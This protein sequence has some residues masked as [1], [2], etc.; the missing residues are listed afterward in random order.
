MDG[1][2]ESAFSVDL[3]S[4]C[5]QGILCKTK[6]IPA[7]VI[8]LFIVLL[9]TGIR[10]EGAFSD[11]PYIFHP[12][13]PR[14]IAII[15]HILKTGDL[16][17]HFFNY[18]SMFLYIND[19]A[20]IPYY[21]IEKLMGR[22][23]TVN[24]IAEP[25]ILVMGTAF[26]PL[27]GTVILSRLVTL[28]FS[29]ASIILLFIAGKELTKIPLVGLLAALMMA[30][31]DCHIASSCSITPDIFVLFWSL[32][33]F[34]ASILILQQ[35]KTWHYVIAGI[36]VG[37]AASSK[38]NGALIVVTVVGAHF[39]RTGWSG[40]R[41]QRLYL[42]F[43][44]SGIGF[45][46]ITPYAILDFKQFGRAIKAEGMHYSTGHA[47][48]EGQALTWYIKYLWQTEGIIAVSAI[49]QIARGVYLRQ[50]ETLLLSSFTIIYIAF[51]SHFVVRN[52]RTL[53]PVIP[54]VLLLGSMLLV[55]LLRTK[56]PQM[57]LKWAGVIL[58]IITFALQLRYE[59]LILKEKMTVDSRTTAPHWIQANLPKGAK[60]AVESYAPFVDPN[61]FA[62]Q[63]IV[64]M[65]DNPPQ[66]YMD[67][68]FNYLI[69][70]RKM[71][72]RFYENPNKY[73]AEVAGYEQFF[74][75]FSLV[76]RFNDGNFE[77]KIYEVASYAQT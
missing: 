16:N 52:D 62:V 54:F 48:M 47:G 44:L 17:P 43:L 1:V 19:L 38:Y 11:L 21:F 15:Q 35:G 41:D 53:L 18:P 58:I 6:K 45:I 77:V 69:F 63:G 4:Q 61:T 31:A 30:L 10:M 74:S 37:F 2:Y 56:K 28:L 70:S 25:I 72:H 66:W 50:K 73:A 65:I 67:N 7:W 64:K 51:I 60:I 29:V 20:Y 23:K 59:R 33:A 76:K 12:D 14:H 42:M 36:A 39:F 32:A 57:L 49:I 13:E 3:K 71:Y 55:D 9:A 40:I 68:N 27:P 26:A 8:L 24:D 75:N 22:F 46:L 5:K 34:L